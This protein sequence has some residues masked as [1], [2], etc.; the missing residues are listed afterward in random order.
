MSLKRAAAVAASAVLLGTLATV[1]ASTAFA[2]PAAACTGGRT[3]PGIR[4]TA[5]T[6]PASTVSRP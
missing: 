6:S 4:T 5:P 1:P 2:A 3:S